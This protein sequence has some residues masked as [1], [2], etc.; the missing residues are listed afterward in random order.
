M[1]R[2]L[3]WSPNYAPELTGIPPLVT[4][5]C[6][7]LAARGHEVEVVTAFPN[8]PQRRIDAAYRGRPWRSEVR[9]GVDVHRS[10]L[11]VRPGESFLDK[12]LYEA[13]FTALSL[14][15]VI[16]RARRADVLVCVVPSLLAAAASA[17]L[18]RGRG[19]RLVLWW[20][21]LVLSAARSLQ[22]LGPLPL[23][24][25]RGART[26]ERVALRAADRVVTCSPGFVDY[27]VAQGGR[28]ERI[29]AVLN[30]VDTDWVTV[31]EPVA[32][33]VTRVLYAGNL[34]YTQGFETV[35][36]AMR[37]LPDAVEL[38]LVGD[39][40]AAEH[41]RRLV[42][43]LPRV[44][45]RPPVPDFGFP[46]LLAGADVQLVLQ[47]R[48]G[49]GVNLPSKIGPYLASGRPIVASI[50]RTTPAAALLEESGGALLVPP[51][52]PA[53]LARA[54]GRLHADRQL[55]AELAQRGRA[56]AVRALGRDEA[57]PRLEHAFLGG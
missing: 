52:D 34:G 1:S 21:D 16:R 50:D 39:G 19:P 48:V 2:I 31:T 43:G 25:L 5:A 33:T 9:D 10:W 20:Q 57:L 24:A 7:W 53:A 28:P 22:G 30:W 38:E 46:A 27:L 13:S 15:R 49:A 51:E 4:D 18:S 26:A 3:V 45:V 42:T 44:H 47:R 23:R 29:T 12:A 54:L 8:Y 11:R 40:N 35:I 41:V 56:F 32:S 37:L 17:G 6:R 14:P 55:R 36:D